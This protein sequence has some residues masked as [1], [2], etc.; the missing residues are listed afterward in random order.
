MHM[1]R[2]KRMVTKVLGKYTDGTHHKNIYCWINRSWRTV[3]GA[4]E[5]AEGGPT[6]RSRRRGHI[7]AVLK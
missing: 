6:S 7:A 4:V 5:E 3:S 1:S 2:V